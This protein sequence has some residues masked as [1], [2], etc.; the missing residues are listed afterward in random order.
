MPFEIY[1]D[2]ECLLKT[3]QSNNENNSSYTEKYQ[4]YIPCSFPYK[5]VC[6]DNKSS[7]N[8]FLYKEKKCRL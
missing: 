2:F 7:K 3:V 5:V 6:V 8:V 4:V 1:A